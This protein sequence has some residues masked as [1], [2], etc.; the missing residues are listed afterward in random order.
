VY[1]K[2]QP[3]GRKEREIKIFHACPVPPKNQPAHKKKPVGENFFKIIPM[4]A[5]K[6]L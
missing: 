3:K 1:H 2:K 5:S 4:V 6:S